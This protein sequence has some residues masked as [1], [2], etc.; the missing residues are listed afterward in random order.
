MMSQREFSRRRRKALKEQFWS[1]LAMTVA[2][3]LIPTGASFLFVPLGIWCVW[4][5]IHDDCVFCI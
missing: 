5:A 3:I 4:A 2:S 1:G